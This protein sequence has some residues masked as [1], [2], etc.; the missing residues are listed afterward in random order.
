MSSGDQGYYGRPVIKPPEWT[1][2]IPVYFWAGG[3]SG[4][5]AVLAFTQRLRGNHPLART[6]LFG[7]A[8]GCAVSAICLI[9]DLKKPSRFMNMLRVFK[10]SSPMSVG[11]YIFSAF[12][13]CIAAASASEITGV[14]RPLGRLSEAAAAFIGPFMSVYTA[15]LICDTVIPAWYLARRSMPLLFATTSCS[16][17]AGLGMLCAPRTSARAAR[18]LGIVAG[19]AVPLALSRVHADVGEFQARAYREGAAGSLASLARMLNLSG[20]VCAAVAGKAPPLQRVAGALLL[21]GG[22]TERF[23]IYRAGQASAKDPAFT[24]HAQQ[25][26]QH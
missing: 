7:S 26:A 16:T 3:L 5:S 13:G 23:A 9:A 18:R 11:V 15:V 20:T 22:L 14:A 25:R 1:D 19:A 6:L 2:L 4:A 24:I 21:A 17:A 10:L 8:A 12:S